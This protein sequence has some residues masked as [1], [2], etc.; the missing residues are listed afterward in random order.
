MIS[1]INALD[2]V[3]TL[4]QEKVTL[5]EAA[6]IFYMI[7]KERKSS[8]EFSFSIDDFIN[9]FDNT[10]SRSSWAMSIDMMTLSDIVTKSKEGLVELTEYGE[11]WVNNNFAA[12]HALST[13][14]AGSAFNKQDN[15]WGKNGRHH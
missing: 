5:Q 3:Y 12:V 15:C 6:M 4:G 13:V 2:Y 7:E 8:K 9:H 14:Y 1:N 10:E 11:Q